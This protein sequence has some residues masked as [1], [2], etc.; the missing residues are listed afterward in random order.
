MAIRLTSDSLL[1]PWRFIAEV[2]GILLLKLMFIV[3][4]VRFIN[5]PETLILEQ[6]N[7]LIIRTE[8]GHCH[9][10]PKAWF[11]YSNGCYYISSER[12]SW[13]ES[14]MACASNAS[15][16]LHRDNEEDMNF[17]R[18]FGVLTWIDFSGNSTFS[19]KV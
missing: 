10:C 12:K 15:N 16:L 9:H 17:L 3:I 7:S 11:M 18:C 1:P 2:L 4:I 8:K 13:S 14:R 5:I 6:K 19:S